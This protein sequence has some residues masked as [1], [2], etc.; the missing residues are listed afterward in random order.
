ME[1]SQVSRVLPQGNLTTDQYVGINTSMG[2]SR[3]IQSRLLVAWQARLL[4]IFDEVV[5]EEKQGSWFHGICQG[6]ELL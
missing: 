1:G 3:E 6:V 2:D 5:L 4:T